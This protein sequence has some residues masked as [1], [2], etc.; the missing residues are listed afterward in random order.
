MSIGVRL[1]YY[2]NILNAGMNL[3][4]YFDYNHFEKARDVLHNYVGNVAGKAILDVG[5][6]RLCGQALLFHS[7]GGK[8]TGI[9]TTEILVNK[10]RFLK[11]WRSLIKNGLEGFGRDVLY[12][13]LGK[14]KAYYRRIRDLSSF[15]LQPDVLDI[16]QM[17]VD[18][19][20]FPDGVFDI[21]I[22]NNAFEHIAN[23]P[24]AVA[25]I[26]RVL[27]PGGITY[28]RIHLF[29]S[30]SGGHNIDLRN[31]SKVPPWKHLRS[32]DYTAPVYLNRLKEQE[33][34]SL[35][36]VR[37]EILDIIDGVCVGRN[38]LTPSIRAELSDYSE[39]ELLKMHITIVARK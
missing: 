33:Y 13:L 5:C 14:N 26:H 18:N 25:E 1:N 35:F 39:E 36:R 7:L 20:S 4:A 37:F 10:P 22:S 11:Y 32:K 6:G 38:L 29:T 2:K 30:L 12:A 8:V 31:P 17:S 3:Q 9:D 27:K 34:I 16:R 23:V 19:M 24:Q 21:V 15:E 28:I